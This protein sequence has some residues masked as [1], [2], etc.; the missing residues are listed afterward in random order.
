MAETKNSFLKGKM[1]KDV[2]NRLLPNGEYRDALNIS[3]GKSEN[4]SVGSLQNILGNSKLTK[5]TPTGSQPFESNTNLVCIGYFVDNEKNRIY[6]FLTD[7]QDP[8]PFNINLPPNTAEMKVTLYDPS[9]SG[10]TYITLLEGTYLNFSI[11]NLITGVN[12]VENLLFWTDNRNQPRKINIDSAISA[13]ADS[14]N[15]YYKNVDQISVAKYAPFLAPEMYMESKGVTTLQ[16]GPITLEAGQTVVQLADIT[17][18]WEPAIGDQLICQ[19]VDVG[20][21]AIVTKI[22]YSGI[23]YNV[24]VS[25]LYPSI[26][27]LSPVTFYRCTMNK[28]PLESTVNGNDNFLADRFV[29]FSYRFKFDD[30]EYSIMAPFTQPAF[31]PEQKGYF[32]NGNEDAAYKST[33]LDWMQN[34]VSS[35]NLL[36]QL[37]DLGANILNSYKIKSIDIL[38]KES[39]ALA[40]KVI[41]TVNVNTIALEAPS[42]NIYSYKYNSQKPRKTLPQAD[43]VR[44][45][46]KVPVRALS[47][48]SAGNRIIYGNFINQNTPPTSLNYNTTVIQK[49]QPFTSW[50]E[51]PNHTLKQNRTYQVGIVLADK[52]GRQSSVILSNA[53]PVVNAGNITFGA[54]SIFFPYKNKDWS[55]DVINWV[56]DQ[57]AVVFNSQIVSN[58]DESLGTPGLYATVSGSIVGSSDGFQVL[59]GTIT[60]ASENI[61]TFTLAPLPA[62]RNVPLTG[63]YLRGK[64]VD[65]V[66]IISTPTSGV[67]IT[68]GAINEIYK[69][70]GT[71]VPPD[72]K[73]SYT[74]NELGWYSYKVVVKQQEQE[75]YNVYVPGMLSGYPR[76]QTFATDAGSGS[77][78]INPSIFPI[79]E[80]DVTCHFVSINDNINKIPRDLSE[81]G[82]NQRQYRSSAQIW[83]RVENTLVNPNNPTPGIA[84]TTNRQYYPTGQPDVVNT[85]APT[86]EL[87][88]LENSNPA[89]IDG[90]ASYNIYQF[91]TSPLIN[92]VST[93]KQVGVIGSYSTTSPPQYYDAM[94]PFLGVYETQPIT[95]AIDIFWETST[96][97]YVSDLNADIL[98]GSDSI[99]SYTPLEFL[100]FENQKYDGSSDITGYVDSP[101]ITN[102]FY[103]E[104]GSG[105]PVLDINTMVFSVVNKS[106]QDVT[107][108]FSLVQDLNPGSPGSPNPLYK[109]WRIKITQ[110]E[111]YFGTNIDTY[112][113]FIFS[114]AITH[115]VGIGPSAVTYNPI[116]TTANEDLKISNV[117]PEITN[118]S[119][120]ST[121]VYSLTSDP[122][123][124][125]IVDVIGKNGSVGNYSGNYLSDLYWDLDPSGSVIPG[126]FSVNSSTGDINVLTNNIP[127]GNHNVKV[128]LKDASTSAGLQTPGGLSTSRIVTLNV[129][130]YKVGCGE[131]SSRTKNNIDG[132][133]T[134][135]T[136]GYI[137]VWRALRKGETIYS[138]SNSY[139]YGWTDSGGTYHPVTPYTWG[140]NFPSVPVGGTPVGINGAFGKELFTN[141]F[142]TLPVAV[143]L[144]YQIG[145]ITSTGRNITFTGTTTATVSPPPTGWYEQAYSYE[146]STTINPAINVPGV[147]RDW[148][149]YNNSSFPITWSGLHGNG[150]IIIGGTIAAGQQVGSV[151]NGGVEPVV[152]LFSLQA[153]GTGVIGGQ[154]N[155]TGGPVSCPV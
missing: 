5:S 59:S 140:I 42:T 38:Y 111:F 113:S 121:P 94:S 130:N 123:I 135:T 63:N 126:L 141:S 122:L 13:P 19:G 79:G 136:I 8:S 99:T 20:D 155:Y 41:E 49:D 138:S 10:N 90:S 83:P 103:F 31:I 86:T 125:P 69:Y 80:E 55:T 142:T 43:T 17:T 28:A 112:G 95:S 32:I 39:D 68:D 148:Y 37:P 67:V 127:I 93:Q 15:P 18:G 154:I 88:F 147:C 46:D 120:N 149:I 44:V 77:L 50:V 137:N 6:Q 109:Y 132:T 27:N 104:N 76:N 98:T 33:V 107:Y 70:S 92:R 11:T 144:H 110:S 129:P 119:V 36:I 84:Y 1:N 54:S 2:D 40:V 29:R 116:I 96:T 25:G 131:W 53:S 34:D 143:I 45:Y 12:V 91:E 21:S 71:N 139:I 52:F 152:R 74:I 16:T 51:Y 114:F 124:G 61:Y 62:Q 106:G 145:I 87:G 64:Y 23:G 66:E 72:I 58:R 56:G 35:V 97:G 7:Y 89:N 151:V 14:S 133:R 101:W 146:C 153:S 22:F 108:N 134:N 150:K 4:Q 78:S 81:V 75:Y 47:Q 82:P 115:T 24:W 85:I 118:P 9:N 73:Y 48:E 100:Y 128:R 26:P 102:W 3:V 105:V 65:Y 30:N 117:I 57:L 60:G